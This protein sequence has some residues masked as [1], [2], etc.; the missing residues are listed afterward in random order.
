MLQPVVVWTSQARRCENSFLKKPQKSSFFA[1]IFEHGSH[2]AGVQELV[3]LIG[4]QAGLLQ[5]G[6]GQVLHGVL[7]AGAAGVQVP[8]FTHAGPFPPT[9]PPWQ[10]GPQG[11]AGVVGPHGHGS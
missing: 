1:V 3:L 8:L 7:Q 11:A 2:T 9:G 10:A 5:A 4:L 6:A